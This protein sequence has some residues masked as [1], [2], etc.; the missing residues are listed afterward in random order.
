MMRIVAI[1]FVLLLAGGVPIAFVMGGVGLIGLLLHPDGFSLLPSLPEQIFNQLNSFPFL[2]IPLFIF[3]GSIMSEGG[4][5]A[6]LMDVA[7]MTVGRGRGGLGSAIV[8]A[9]LFF[10]GISGSSSADTAAIGKVTLPGLRRQGYPPQFAAALL[11]SAGATSTLIPPST[12]FILIGVVANMSIAGLF[13]AG[14]IPAC[15]NALGLI[16]LVIYVAHKNGYGTEHQPFDSKAVAW[17]VFKA[18]PGLFMIV[19]IIGG[20]LG[21]V[22][23]PTEASA[24]AVVYGILITTV[25][26]RSLTIKRLVTMFR[27]TIEIAGMVLTVIAMSAVLSYMLTIYQIP[28]ALASS[29]DAFT[30]NKYVF[31]LLVQILFFAI[32]TVVDTTPALLILMPILTPMA[33]SRGVEPIHFGILVETNIAL[34]MA[35]PPAGNCLFT[36]CAIVKVPLEQVIRP[37][38]PF[39]AVLIVTMMIITYVEGF[40]M[41]LPRL[42]GV[43]N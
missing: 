4:I 14:L 31:L 16:L 23:T 10:H 26:Y 7:N 17:A 5:A 15:V 41:F 13:A 29:L 20:I 21:G 28:T 27:E 22:F 6:R 1:S 9:S 38:L 12:D 25:V 36:A 32:G 39:L 33:V 40:S 24:V 3:A 11:A 2:T 42:L 35:H 34:G 43:A 30:N 8:V 37:L 18:I 19:I